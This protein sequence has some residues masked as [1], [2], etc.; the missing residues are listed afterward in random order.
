MP[1]P[2]LIASRPV[3]CAV[4]PRGG[5]PPQTTAAPEAAPTPDEL[6]PLAD[7]PRLHFMPRRK[8]K[9]LHVSTVFRWA[10]RGIRGAVLHTVQAGGVR[11]TTVPSLLAFF[12]SVRPASL[13]KAAAMPGDSPQ[14]VEAALRELRRMLSRDATCAPGRG[15][16][17]GAS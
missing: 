8:G 12:E 2:Q 3:T 1:H 5:E 4:R 16:K 10:S 17:G 13:D 6:I 7:V 15:G 9:P 11:C 14:A